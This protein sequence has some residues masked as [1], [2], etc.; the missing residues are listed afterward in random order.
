MRGRL[1]LHLCTWIL[2]VTALLFARCRDE[3]PGTIN[4]VATTSVLGSIIKAIGRNH[5]TV[6]TIV[7]AG[8]CPG[9][10]D[11][12]SQHIKNLEDSKAFFN[13][14][15]EIWIEKLITAA[16]RKPALFTINVTGNIMV[17]P[18]HKQAAAYVAEVLCSLDQAHQSQYVNN[19]TIYSNAIDSVTAILE[20]QRAGYD[21]VKVVC[22]ELQEEFI[23]WVGLDVVTTY[24][25][26][27]DL[28]PKML[29][30][31]I[32]KSRDAHVFL[33]IDNMQSGADAGKIIAEQINARRVVLTNFPLNGSYIDAVMENFH[34]LQKV[35]Q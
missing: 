5:V 1:L 4:V 11:I 35:I 32:T 9:H 26:A 25:R 3:Q 10:F 24:A 16:D 14:G 6:T 31:I 15:W 20:K 17:P 23:T 28:T 22:A 8:M 29:E 7:P 18:M 19:F 12:T 21:S 30:Q 13:H 2:V 27:E 34:K 33:V